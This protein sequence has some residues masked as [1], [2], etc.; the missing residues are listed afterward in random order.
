MFI[1]VPEDEAA[2]EA[3][4][5]D[6]TSVAAFV[7]E[8]LRD[9][10]SLE[11]GQAFSL[12]IRDRAKD[13]DRH[14][15]TQFAQSDRVL[16]LACMTWWALQSCSS[17]SVPLGLALTR[18]RDMLQEDSEMDMFSIG[19]DK[20]YAVA[21]ATSIDAFV[22]AT[23]EPNTEHSDGK[24][25]QVLQASTDDVYFGQCTTAPVVGHLTG[26]LP[27]S[28]LDV[29]NDDARSKWF[30]IPLDVTSSAFSHVDF[31]AD[32]YVV[33]VDV[34]EAAIVAVALVL[35]GHPS[36]HLCRF[37]LANS[38]ALLPGHLTSGM[39]VP[40]DAVRANEDGAFDI[41]SGADH[42]ADSVARETVKDNWN[43]ALA[44]ADYDAKASADDDVVVLP[45][46]YQSDF[47]TM[48][49]PLSKEQFLAVAEV[50]YQ[51]TSLCL[52]PFGVLC[53][54]PHVV[55]TTMLEAKL[56]GA[57]ILQEVVE[58]ISDL[59]YDMF[60][61][62]ESTMAMSS[63][64]WLHDSRDAD[65]VAQMQRI[66]DLPQTLMKPPPVVDVSDA[67]VD[68]AAV[69]A[70][71]ESIRASVHRTLQA[72]V[73]WALTA[74]P[75]VEGLATP[76]PPQPIAQLS[77]YP[78]V[79]YQLGYKFTPTK[80][81]RT[82][83]SSLQV[84]AKTQAVFEGV[85]EALKVHECPKLNAIQL[86]AVV[87]CVKAAT[88]EPLEQVLMSTFAS[89]HVVNDDVT[90]DEAKT[91]DDGAIAAFAAKIRAGD[92]S[93]RRRDDAEAVRRYTEALNCVPV[94]HSSAVEAL[95][96]R[97]KCFIRSDKVD[98][99]LADATLALDLSPYSADAY[100]CK[101]EIDERQKEFEKALQH[102]V[103]AFILGGSRV[104]EQA[105]VIER[106]SKLV[107]RE[108]AKGIWATMV[109]RHEL[110]S[111]WLVDSYF[112]SFSRDAD[113]GVSTLYMTMPKATAVDDDVVVLSDDRF[114]DLFVQ[115]VDHKRSKRYTAA[116]TLF[117]KLA[118][119]VLSC[120]ATDEPE[121]PDA[122]ADDD[123]VASAPSKKLYKTKLDRHVV[124]L[125][126]HA[127]FLY[128]AG[129]VESALDVIDHALALDSE[130]LNS[131][132]KKAGFLCELGEFGQADEWFQ[133]AAAMDENS[134][135]V[136]L[137]RGQM[138]LILGDYAA[139]V[140]SL[141]KS[142]TRCDS[143]A[144]THIS[145][146][147]A[148]YKAGSVY[149]SLD[150]FKTALELFPTSHEVRLFYGDVLSDR[151]DYGQAMEHLRKAVE[152]SPECPLPWLN[153]GRI[154]V[155]TNDGNHAITHFEQA[156]Q[157]DPRCSAAHLDLAQ[158]YFAQGKVDSAMAHFDL[159]TTTCR[160][161]PEVED[162]CACRS[163]A[164]M[165][166]KATTILGVELRHMLKTQ[167]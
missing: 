52:A 13:V 96:K 121:N 95:T 132:I 119:Y 102:H 36:V 8:N 68:A 30:L 70:V 109:K 110:P 84:K 140:S 147:M 124:A 154:F 91:T 80:S 111:G 81:S 28:P 62:N 72:K 51:Y 77:W 26:S 50:I 163:V 69:L 94:H 18:K 39:F 88:A 47:F 145:Y 85:Q 151:A 120:R 42:K 153:A 64:K 141:R 82:K 106:V 135:D 35:A 22:R 115:A 127:T 137:H 5:R 136:Y 125:N 103:L 3:L 112:L 49:S 128:I 93:V 32:V 17:L 16:G 90:M 97:A 38:L 14:A 61:L 46:A 143:L 59:V 79:A 45:H 113:A 4:L 76:K 131:V 162:A 133:H 73:P 15:A 25:P 152:F 148:L 87:D 11:N 40:S 138:E 21:P 100:A 105:E 161:L 6:R 43:A 10:G 75:P 66:Q 54:N 114:D 67:P 78:C 41:S 157:V 99:A 155:A 86:Q 19:D 150:V 139:A 24:K 20:L 118:A 134:G 89:H 146:G 129:D 58:T 159:A 23:A 116:Q 92:Y 74:V 60:D 164:M 101:G 2:I 71:V 55:N 108:Q 122:V 65:C 166:L 160:F 98:L 130:H 142:M 149:Q 9:D 1:N 123:V 158:V 167:K 48:P 126:F 31:T 156:L 104:I 56:K 33:S 7:H 37:G 12:H 117:A 144:V 27:L 44:Q 57:P 63:Q 165:Q 29:L 83:Q 53:P 107:G 34:I